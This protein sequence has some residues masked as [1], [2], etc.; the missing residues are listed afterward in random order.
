MIPITKSILI[1]KISNLKSQN[2]VIIII[3]L[4]FVISGCQMDSE[5]T[6]P[7]PNIILIVADDLGIHQLGCYG[8]EFYET[9]NIDRLA[10]NG[11]KFTNAYAA[12]T[13]CSPTRASILTGKYPA[14]LHLTDYIPGKTK[15]GKKLKVPE[16]RKYLS[17]HNF[18]WINASELKG[19]NSKI[20][21]DYNIYATPTL[22]LLDENRQIMSKPLSMTKIK[23]EFINR[24]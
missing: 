6:L 9:P 5:N 3:S 15:P 18:N 8:S 4:L 16:W 21:I 14:R 7:T 12:A 19:W 11:M 10:K 23:E 1:K 20:A 2:L 17:E 24:K 22:L 13:V